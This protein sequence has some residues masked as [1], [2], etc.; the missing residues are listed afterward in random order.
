MLQG[1]AHGKMLRVIFFV[2]TVA[3]N[4]LFNAID[5]DNAAMINIVL[6]SGKKVR[7]ARR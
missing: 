7:A 4:E 5:A 6:K 3:G 1:F 2:S